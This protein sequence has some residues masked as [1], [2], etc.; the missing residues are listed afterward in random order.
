MHTGLYETPWLDHL[1]DLPKLDL[2]K[3]LELKFEKEFI[4]H[5]LP[6][7]LI[8]PFPKPIPPCPVPFTYDQLIAATKLGGTMDPTQ[9]LLGFE[10]GEITPGFNIY[11]IDSA[12]LL[13][14]LFLDL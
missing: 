1:Y 14:E 7:E 11:S 2:D 10:V 8:R 6:I 5:E 4:K 13:S 12:A 3:L 9:P